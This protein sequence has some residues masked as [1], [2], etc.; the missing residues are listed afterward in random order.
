MQKAS[1]RGAPFFTSR[2]KRGSTSKRSIIS[3]RTSL[4]P[5]GM[6]GKVNFRKFTTQRQSNFTFDARLLMTLHITRSLPAEGM[7]SPHAILRQKGCT[8]R[9][10]KK[11]DEPHGPSNLIQIVATAYSI[12]SII[13]RIAFSSAPKTRSTSLPSLTRISVGIASTLYDSATLPALSTSTATNL[14]L[15]L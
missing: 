11:K 8:P 1:K 2:C 4:L 15:P 12:P 7:Y 5:E 10:H 14:T 6:P 13:D 9:L 3:R